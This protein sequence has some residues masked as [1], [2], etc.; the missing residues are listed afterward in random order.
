[1]G[2]CDADLCTAVN[3]VIEC[4][5]GLVVAAGDETEFLPLPVAGLMSDMD[6]DFV[7]G[8]MEVIE[9]KVSGLGSRLKSPFMTLSFMAL[10]VIPKL[11]MSDRGLFDSEAFSFTSVWV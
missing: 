10:L 11:K 9:E 5:G 8:K 2:V 4:Q 1:M 6:A 7:A 3:K